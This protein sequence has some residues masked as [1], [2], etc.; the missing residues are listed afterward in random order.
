[1]ILS[2][3]ASIGLAA[4]LVAVLP[5]LP[6]EASGLVRTY[7]SA[8]GMD[9]NS[10]VF[11]NPCLTLSRA[12]TSTISGGTVSCLDSGE[13]SNATITISVTIDCAGTS[14]ELGSL[15]IN[16]PGIL[17]TLKNLTIAQ[18][19][20]TGITYQQG[21]GLILDN[22]RIITSTSAISVTPTTA[23]KLI[24]SNSIFGNNSSG[25]VIKPGAGG[26]VF[27]S[28]DHVTIANNTGG[29]LKTDTTTGGPITVD[30]SNSTVSNN[31]GN[32]LNAVS[33]AGG[34]N[35]LNLIHNVIAANGSSG[36]QANGAT[37]AA[38]VNN[39]VLDSNTVGATAAVGGGRVLTYG[40]NSIVGSPGSGFT[41]SATLQ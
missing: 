26:S 24:V 30:I 18:G 12:L 17:V 31:A 34:T 3:L 41:G 10:C 13:F 15:T 35:M 38:L 39:T 5:T 23:A 19:L 21:A 7:V 33:G 28:F 36:V 16:G 40:N 27:A 11:T 37:A 29:G 4:A 9:M 25:V 14:A 6:A 1:M 32:G 20:P 22:V 8:N 2:K